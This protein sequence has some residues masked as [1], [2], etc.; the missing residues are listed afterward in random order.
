MNVGAIHAYFRHRRNRRLSECVTELHKTLGR[1]VRALDVGGSPKF[2]NTV[3]ATTRDRCEVDLLNLEFPTDTEGHDVANVNL[4]VGDAR[5][6]SRFADQSYD[7]VVSNSMIEHVGRWADIRQCCNELRRVGRSGWVQTPAFA[8]P[9]DPHCM[10]PFI[11]WFAPPIRRRMLQAFGWLPWQ[12]HI[13]FHEYRYWAD[14]ANMMSFVELKHL[15][16]RDT[17]IVERLLGLPKSYIVLWQA[18]DS[19]TGPLR[20][21]AAI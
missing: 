21:Q 4:M 2:W 7:L 12:R 18:E 11:H 1:P 9:V 20:Q 10:L 5:D 16:P 6:L 8:F 17:I 13:E 15:F 3:E 19:V 14:Y